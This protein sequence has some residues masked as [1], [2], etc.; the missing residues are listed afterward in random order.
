MYWKVCVSDKLLLLFLLCCYLKNQM[1]EYTAIIYVQLTEFSKPQYTMDP[2][3]SQEADY[4]QDNLC[5][6][7]SWLRLV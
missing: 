5:S 4:Q 2:A 3:P 7:F 6:D 1:N